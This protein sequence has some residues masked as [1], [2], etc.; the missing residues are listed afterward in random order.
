LR[1]TPRE[2]QWKAFWATLELGNLRYTNFAAGAP[3]AAD[4]SF[5]AFSS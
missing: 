1:L 4:T 5:A 3:V 2:K